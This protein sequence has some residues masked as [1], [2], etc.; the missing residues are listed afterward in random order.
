[1]KNFGALMRDMTAAACAGDGEGVARCFTESGVYHDVFYGAF[2]GHTR[3]AEMIRDYFHRDAQAFRWDVH[4]PIAH[5]DIGYTRY[6]FSYESKLSGFEGKRTMFEGVAIV[7]LERGLIAS[8]TE[9]ANT[10]PGL[11]RL[12]FAPERLARI[13]AKQAEELAAR[14]ESKLH[15]LEAK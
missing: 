15:G 2:K 4:D 7:R 1:M 9:V 12:G 13:Y 11:C 5:G 6:V 3:I 14:D 10:A 8:Y